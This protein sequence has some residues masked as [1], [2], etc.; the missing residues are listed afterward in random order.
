MYR[1][2]SKS[3]ASSIYFRHASDRLDSIRTMLWYTLEFVVTGLVTGLYTLRMASYDCHIP[4]N[5]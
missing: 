3:R 1:V 4:T 5:S 2:L